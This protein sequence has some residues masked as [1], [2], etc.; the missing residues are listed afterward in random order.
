MQTTLGT[1][2]NVAKGDT[3]M[4]C[5]WLLC[6]LSKCLFQ[7]SFRMS[8]EQEQKCE[9]Q[10]HDHSSNPDFLKPGLLSTGQAGYVS[11]RRQ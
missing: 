1:V 7:T 10:A 8:A 4:G 5:L 11:Y 6:L 2:V 9:R 3:E